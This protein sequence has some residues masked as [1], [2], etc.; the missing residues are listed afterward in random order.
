MKRIPKLN[1]ANEEELAKV[2]LASQD[3]MQVLTCLIR[4]PFEDPDLT[5]SV[6]VL[7]TYCRLFT[8]NKVNEKIGKRW[9]AGFTPEEVELHKQALRLRSNH[10]AHTDGDPKR[11]RIHVQGESAGGAIN[12]S[13]E[14]STGIFLRPDFYKLATMVSKIREQIEI[15]KKRLVQAVIRDR[16]AAGYA[17]V[18]SL[19]DRG[20]PPVQTSR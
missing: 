10:L 20:P 8:R 6:V 14:Y 4:L 7:T 12:Y 2:L 5:L 13:T 11:V 18:F 15:D 1:Y 17:T 9:I 3:M 19:G 16:I